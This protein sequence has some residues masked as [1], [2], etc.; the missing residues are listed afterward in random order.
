MKR[1][2]TLLFWLVAVVGRPPQIKAVI[3]SSG[4][5]FPWKAS[6]WNMEECSI[7]Q[8]SGSKAEEGCTEVPDQQARSAPG[9]LSALRSC[10]SLPCPG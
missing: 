2:Q 7:P 3:E 10:V 5:G 6:P 8:Q 1:I 9:S 4:V